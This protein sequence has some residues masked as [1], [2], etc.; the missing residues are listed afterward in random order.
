MVDSMMEATCAFCGKKFQISKWWFNWRNER[1]KGKGVFCSA[2][3]SNSAKERSDVAKLKTSESLKRFYETHKERTAGLVD[4]ICAKCAKT[5]QLKAYAYRARI[6]HNKDAP[7]YCSKA[8]AL[9]ARI[10]RPETRAKLSQLQTNVSV[11]SRGRP[12][13]TVDVDTRLKLSLRKKLSPVMSFKRHDEDV[14]EEMHKM[15]ITMYAS[16]RTRNRDTCFVQDGR[17]IAFELERKRWFTSVK[18][19]M[20]QYIGSNEYDKVI[21]I[22]KDLAGQFRGKW[23]FENGEWKQVG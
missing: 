21:L 4:V 17:H 22:W 14:D 15:G 8:C 3:C 5:F 16:D 18:K 13:H 23:E 6:R 7:L 19:K 12:G 9:S 1:N 20:R 2:H 10:V 11:P